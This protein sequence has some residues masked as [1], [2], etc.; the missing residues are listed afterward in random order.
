MVQQPAAV[1]V[2]VECD[3]KKHWPTRKQI[4]SKRQLDRTPTSQ[5]SPKNQH[6][7]HSRSQR[8]FGGIDVV[9]ILVPE[10][11]VWQFEATPPIPSCRTESGNQLRLWTT[12]IPAR[13]KPLRLTTREQAIS[14]IQKKCERDEP[15]RCE[16]LMSLKSKWRSMSQK[17]DRHWASESGQNGFK[18]ERTQIVQQYDVDCVPRK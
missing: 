6:R 17:C 18:H 5:P 10:E 2:S 11:D 7:Q 16:S 14:S 15:H 13:R 4:L 9:A 3:W 8:V 1:A 12:R